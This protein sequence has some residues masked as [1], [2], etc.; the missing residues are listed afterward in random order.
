MLKKIKDYIKENNN[1]LNTLKHKLDYTEN[2]RNNLLL[3]RNQLYGKLKG[4]ENGLFETRK[5]LDEAKDDTN[6]KTKYIDELKGIQENY[7]YQINKAEELESELNAK[8]ETIKNLE[9][10]KK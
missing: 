8:N 4:T 5:K 2:E 9:N 6:E 7:D 1:K 10:E 3:D